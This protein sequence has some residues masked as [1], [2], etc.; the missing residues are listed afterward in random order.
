MNLFLVV[1]GCYL[2]LYVG[3]Y[4]FHHIGKG[5]DR[6]PTPVLISEKLA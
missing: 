6:L 4:P 5:G 3:K 2:G 1:S